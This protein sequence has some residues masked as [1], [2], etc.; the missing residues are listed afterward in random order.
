[1]NSLVQRVF[2]KEYKYAVVAVCLI[3][4][5]KVLHFVLH[6]FAGE[7]KSFLRVALCFSIME[8]TE[9]L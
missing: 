5:F 1:M 9:E 2:P 6:N 4:V 3:K 7:Q 8:I